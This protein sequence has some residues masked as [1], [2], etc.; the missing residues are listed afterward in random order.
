MYISANAMAVDLAAAI[1]PTVLA[2]L[3]ERGV[4]KDCETADDMLVVDVLQVERN[5]IVH[6]YMYADTLLRVEHMVCKV[7]GGASSATRIVLFNQLMDKC[8][9]MVTR[10][11]RERDER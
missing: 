11:L 5:A 9:G 7:K 8:K 2:L 1:R 3:V 4:A 6:V 10:I